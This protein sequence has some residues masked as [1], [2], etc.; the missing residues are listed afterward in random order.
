MENVNEYVKRRGR[1]PAVGVN[2]PL[3]FSV[4]IDSELMEAVGRTDI[5]DRVF[6]AA[7]SEYVRML[8][9]FKTKQKYNENRG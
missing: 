5:A 9:E 4:S 6:S 8:N 3:R 1:K 2:E 7:K